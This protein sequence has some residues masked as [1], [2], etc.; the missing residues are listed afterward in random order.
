MVIDCAALGFPGWSTCTALREPGEREGDIATDAGRAGA[1]D[2]SRAKRSGLH[3]AAVAD[4]S[5]AP[6]GGLAR[7]PRCA[8]PG[9]SRRAAGTCRAEGGARLRHRRRRPVMSAGVMR[10]PRVPRD[11]DLPVWCTPRP[12]AQRRRREN[13]ARWRPPGSAE[14]RRPPGGDGAARH[15]HRGTVGAR[16]HVAHV[17]PRSVRAIAR[18]RR[19]GC[20]SPPSGPAHFTLTDNAVAASFRPACRPPAA[21]LMTRTLR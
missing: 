17:S 15:P 16:L 18:R 7:D 8:I 9:L 1:Y 6:R 10:R 19:A 4:S 20:A 2:V 3:S 14:C 12:H 11:L 13:E 21:S 5:G